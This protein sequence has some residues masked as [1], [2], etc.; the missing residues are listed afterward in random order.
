METERN[1]DEVR[2]KDV[3]RTLKNVIKAGETILQQKDIENASYDSFILMSDLLNIDKSYYY[4]HQDNAVTEAVYEEYMNHIEKRA[5][6][7]PLQHIIGYTEFW[8][9]RFYVN[10]HVLV[11][12]QD[13]EILVEEAIKK[14]TPHSRILDMC[15]GSGCI[16]ISIALETDVTEGIG[17]DISKEALDV[18]EMNKKSLKADKVKFIK[19]NLFE[20]LSKDSLFDLIISNPPYIRTQV[21]GEL[22]EEVKNHDPFIALDGHEDGLFFYQEITR[23][24]EEFLKIGGW[25]MYEIGFDQSEDVKNI[26]LSCGFENIQIVKD[27]TGLDRVVVGQKLN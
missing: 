6:H 12:R 16:L 3:V 17:V 20:E 26:M 9:Y 21:I 13:T 24:S 7:V 22:A 10:E 15:T 8:K 2:N 18:A 25:L 14:V 27:L 11:P 4:L 19:S 1:M 23:Q 5:N